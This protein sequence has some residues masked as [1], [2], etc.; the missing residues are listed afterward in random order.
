MFWYGKK[1]IACAAREGGS[2]LS[3]WFFSLHLI[4]VSIHKLNILLVL[5]S[6]TLLVTCLVLLNILNIVEAKT[7][8]HPWICPI[9]L[10]QS[11]FINMPV[12]SLYYRTERKTTATN[13]IVF[14]MMP[15]KACIWLK[16]NSFLSEN[17]FFIASD[18]WKNLCFILQL[19]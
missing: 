17:G 6:K 13:L 4:W 12:L 9:K 5:F 1:N 2:S 8:R 19:N 11:M 3:C 16:P 18:T 7:K 14:E 15:W 10:C